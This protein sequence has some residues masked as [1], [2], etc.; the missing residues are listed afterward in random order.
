MCVYTASLQSVV[1]LLL[2]RDAPCYLILQFTTG[3]TL[4][5]PASSAPVPT[6]PPSYKAVL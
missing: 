6:K 1:A 3:S 4:T 2:Q 5:L